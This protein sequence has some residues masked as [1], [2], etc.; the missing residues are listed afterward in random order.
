MNPKDDH[1]GD[2]INVVETT[3]ELMTELDNIRVKEFLRD[4]ANNDEIFGLTR[5][6]QKHFI[7]I[8]DDDQNKPHIMPVW[9]IKSRAMKVRDEDFEDCDIIEVE[10]ELFGEWLSKLRDEDKA[11]A[12]DLKPGVVGTVVS[13]QK[14]SNEAPF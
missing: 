4:V 11:V 14:L 5:K 1:S 3:S 9:S 12:I 8:S 6:D 2:I 10:S 7:L 13:A